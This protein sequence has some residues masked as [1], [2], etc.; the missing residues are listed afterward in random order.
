MITEDL[1]ILQVQLE[2]PLDGVYEE[3]EDANLFLGIANTGNTDDDLL[4]VRGPDFA[5]AQLLVDGEP[6]A[7][8]VQQNDNVYVGAEGAPRITLI[9]LKRSL[10]SSQSIPVILV[11][12]D[13]GEMIVNA[14]VAS[15][16]RNPK[17]T[18]DF[19]N[20]AED[21]TQS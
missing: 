13:A 20:P 14:P 7:I 2:Y 16:G 12:E 10:R 21:P 18:Y 17:P 19:P 1:S 9:D 15:E 11:F 6:G 8:R 3:G 4:D 5:N